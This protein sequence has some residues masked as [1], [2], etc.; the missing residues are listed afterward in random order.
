[1]KIKILGEYDY[2]EEIQ[3]GTITIELI[4]IGNTPSVK[5]AKNQIIEQFRYFSDLR[6]HKID[7]DGTDKKGRDWFTALIDD[8]I[9]YLEVTKW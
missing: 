6:G 3:Q 9:T 7:F 4:D 8:K 5:D 2:D 1:M